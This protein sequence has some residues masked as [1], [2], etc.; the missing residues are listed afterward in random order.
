M[1]VRPYY[2]R[3]Y[4]KF[5]WLVNFHFRLFEE[6]TFS[7]AVLKHSLVLTKNNRRNLN[8]Y[9]DRYKKTFE[10]LTKF[11][12]VLDSVVLPGTD[13]SIKSANEFINLPAGLL[14]SKTFI[15]GNNCSAQSQYSGLKRF[16]P[17]NPITKEV[18]L[19]FAFRERDRSVART[20]ASALSGAKQANQ[21]SSPSFSSLFHTKVVIDPDP[22]ILRDLSLESINEALKRVKDANTRS[23]KLM[24][25]FVIP[26]SENNGYLEIKSIF[27]HEGISTQVCTTDVL[28]DKY[29]LKWSIANIAVQIFC[30]L[31]GQPWKVSPASTDCLI[32]GIGQSHQVKTENGVSSVTRY[33]AFSVLTENSGLFKR[34]QILG[35]SSDK[36]SYIDSLTLELTKILREES[37][38]YAQVVIH[39]PFRLK[40]AEIEA[41]ENVVK[42]V[43]LDSTLQCKFWVIKINL[44]ND[45]F[46]V[47]PSVNSN[48]PFE[49]TLVDI[50]ANQR[51]MWFEG[52]NPKS[53]TVTKAYPGPAHLELLRVNEEGEP[54][55]ETIFRDLLNLSGANWRGFNARSIPVSVLY[56]QLISKFVRRFQEQDLPVPSEINEINPWFL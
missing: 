49:G 9:H 52:M 26:K 53:N 33:F 23:E 31:G 40:R 39:V 15:F 27:T 48:V 16:G 45:Y 25:V 21:Y 18:H 37:E 6:V 44:R 42:S 36:K 24:P 47:N 55:D 54:V 4:R 19:L 20:L 22:I 50:G 28:N 46:G 56:C 12:F 5:G 38:K 11:K 43:S 10:I 32:I 14:P 3:R 41:I 29:S 35:G 17:L 8:Y 30:K 1:I 51:L 13:K 34:L 7:K 2:L